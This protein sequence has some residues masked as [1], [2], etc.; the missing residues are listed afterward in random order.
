MSEKIRG[1]VMEPGQ[2][3]VLSLDG[4]LVFVEE[5]TRLYS[6]VVPLPEQ[7]P[8]RKEVRYFVPGRVGMKKISPFAGV[9]KVVPPEELSSVNLQF[10]SEFKQVRDEKGNNEVHLAKKEQP[11][12]VTKAGP[13]KKRKKKSDI[14]E[15]L[16]AKCQTCGEQRGHPKHP[17]DHEF[18]PPDDATPAPPAKEPR[19]PRASG[20]RKPSAP[21]TF[22]WIG[23]DLLVETLAAGNPKYKDGNSGRAIVAA[24]QAGASDLAAVMTTLANHD[25]WKLVPEER[26][27]FALKQLTAAKLIEEV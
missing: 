20:G 11:V 2:V 12:T 13:K 5:T 22:K 23:S 8:T 10:L 17:S 27:A 26:V 4:S 18:V 24:I 7:P 21:S 9:D 1:V 19:Q 16:R 15:E 25:R 3:V 14:D 6:G